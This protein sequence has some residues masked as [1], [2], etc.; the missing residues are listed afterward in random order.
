MEEKKN[1]WAYIIVFALIF[2]VLIVMYY[3][4]NR[5]SEFE[6]DPTYFCVDENSEVYECGEYI[7][8]INRVPGA[9][10]TYY[11]KD[12]KLTEQCF[13]VAPDSMSEFCR[14]AMDWDCSV[15]CAT[16]GTNNTE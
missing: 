1:T 12:S 2:I 5:S 16:T 4:A 9:G 8:T 11:S 14:Q 15:I 13:V 7:K 3:M 10:A 6:L